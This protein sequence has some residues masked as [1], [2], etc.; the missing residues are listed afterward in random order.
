[1]TLLHQIFAKNALAHPSHPFMDDDRFGVYDIRESLALSQQTASLLSEL[2]LKPGDGLV[3]K[4]TRSASTATLLYATQILG[5][6]AIPIDEREDGE[7]AL[8][9]DPRI[10]A[11]A[12]QENE[13]GAIRIWT[14]RFSVGKKT[15][16]IPSLPDLSC[17]FE[18]SCHDPNADCLWVFTSGSEGTQ[19]IVRHSQKTLFSHCERYTG[20][21]SCDESDR[22]IFLLPMNHVFGLALLLMAVY[23]GFSLFFP[24]TLELDQVIDYVVERRITY[25]DHVPSYHYMVAKRAEERGVRFT[26]L[27][28][29]L[30]GGAPMPESRFKEIEDGLGMKL[31]PVYGASEIITIAALGDDASFERRR[32]TVGQPL[33]QTE[34]RIVDENGETMPN[35]SAGEIVVRSPSL[36]LGYLG[37]DSGIDKEGFFATGDIGYL[38]EIGDLHITGRKKAVIIRNGNNISCADVEK[39]LIALGCVERCCVVPVPDSGSGEAPGAMVVL[40]LDATN[41][42]FLALMKD[43]LPKNMWPTKIIFVDEMPMLGSGKT[44]RIAVKEILCSLSSN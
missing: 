39:R 8:K 40:S 36:M 35:G 42:S 41:G 11:I 12:Y 10:K 5:L 28:N 17:N 33:E 44:D 14:F 9:I 21:S 15:I 30:T 25:L 29:G 18:N 31:L 20:P 2:G 13:K 37:E 16:E 22:G 32:T 24:S 19:K 27:R 34:L 26:S 38:D 1:M 43:S 4:A 23:V 6:I 7:N 3:I